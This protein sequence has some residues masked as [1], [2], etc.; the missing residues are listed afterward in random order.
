M[1][2]SEIEL[3]VSWVVNRHGKE[4]V[5]DSAYMEPSDVLGLPVPRAFK[6]S[7]S[8]FG[9]QRP[10]ASVR[11]NWHL[12]DCDWERSLALWR[13]GSLRVGLHSDITLSESLRLTGSNAHRLR[14]AAG[15]VLIC[16]PEGTFQSE[17]VCILMRRP[18]LRAWAAIAA[19]S[20][21]ATASAGGLGP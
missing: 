19:G 11:V 14:P 17:S 13:S 2:S 20:A 8:N 18:W 21:L 15:K 5:W 9:R 12:Q 16:Q 7:V 6:F 3:D 1:S 10:R 4:Q